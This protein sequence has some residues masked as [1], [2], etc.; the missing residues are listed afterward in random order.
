M[1]AMRADGRMRPVTRASMS[2][3]AGLPG[4]APDVNWL[5]ELFRDLDPLKAPFSVARVDKAVTALWRGH[6]SLGPARPV[7]DV[8]Y[9]SYDA[10][11]A[12]TVTIISDIAGQ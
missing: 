12:T 11:A 4:R 10:D 9:D 7:A 2:I 6:E 8:G 5:A 1:I 3:E